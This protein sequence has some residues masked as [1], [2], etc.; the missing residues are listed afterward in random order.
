[1]DRTGSD[2]QLAETRALPLRRGLLLYLPVIFAG[3]L[4]GAFLRYPEHSA[5]ILFPPY[6]ALTAVLI[7]SHRRH[8]IV[9]AGL[10]VL[11]HF[12]TSMGHWPLSWIALAT[13]A[14]LAR[15]FVAALLILRLLGPRPRLDGVASLVQFVFAAAIVAPAVGATIGASNVMLHDVPDTYAQLRRG[16]F[17]SNALTALTMLPL[18]LGVL[19]SPAT[20]KM[21]RI[22]RRRSIETVCF[23]V[24]L[25]VTYA[26]VLLSLSDERYDLATALYA[27]IPVLLW[28]GLRFGP[29]GT[30][31]ALSVLTAAAII[32]TDRRMVPGDGAVLRLQVFVF[33]TAMPM[34][35][36]AVVA[37]ALQ[38]ALLLYRAL[39]ASLQDQVAILDATGVVIRV[40]D[41]WR[42]H[43]EAPSL[44]PFERAHVG[45]NFLSACRR[46]A[47]M[48]VLL[49]P[50][51]HDPAPGRLLDGATAVLRGAARRFETDY[52][53]T[54]DGIREW[55]IMRVEALERADG[56]A[57]VTRTNV[58]LRR[59]AQ[60]E[61]EEQ[62][63]Q[64]SHLGRV[65]ALG[66]L[67]GAMAHE[68]RQP[69]AAILAN[70][71][72]ARHFIDRKMFDAEELRA[73]LTDIV[74]EDR[75]AA[76]VIEGLRA[77]HKR[78]D[79]RLR[80]IEPAELVHEAL[81]LT[82]T[83]IIT[84]GVTATGIIEPALPLV[85]ADRVQIQHV[86]LN[87]VLNA[88]ESMSEKAASERLLSISAS[89]AGKDVRFSVRDSGSGIRPDLIE[90]LFDPFLTTKTAGLGLGLSIARTVVETHGGQIWAEN[91]DESGA[92]VSFLL[93]AVAV[94]TDEIRPP[95]APYATPSP[96]FMGI[97]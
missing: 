47:E 65:A 78:S 5:A 17:V 23:G 42:R 1:M 79:I 30:G 10:A 50:E 29:A 38:D 36:V 3:N 96:V 18:L 59:Q 28:A 92:M 97:E 60:A 89:S 95:D 49:H 13:V 7:A 35:C 76:D 33:L 56:G 22:G 27:P 46:A 43:A 12:A 66:Q 19:D 11:F 54:H 31:L 45:D 39:L 8:W 44:C 72:A 40:N 14:N 48:L 16:W 37:N 34:L 15:A 51:N 81:G 61:I 77:M 25:G 21:A 94:A 55:F 87:L 64:I 82:H 58:S 85:M 26:L 93:P 4:V 80:P 52:E 6:A 73:I 74:T 63:R 86:L 67:S 75:R 88:C 69:L 70:A 84:R 41:S 20:W 62:R 24:A 9:Y 53:L 57:V 91:G 71:E 83:E 32:G 68:L 2:L 90:H